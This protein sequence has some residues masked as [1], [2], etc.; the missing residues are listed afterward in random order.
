MVE[1]LE[2]GHEPDEIST[3]LAQGPGGRYLRDWIYGAIDGGVTTFAIVAGVAGAELPN[4]VLLILGCANLL[5]DGFAMAASNYSA[6]KSERDDYNRV[7]DIE[8]RHVRL[9]PEGEREEVRQIFAAKGFAGDDLDRIVDVI[10]GD[11]E[12]WVRTMA[13]EE[14]GHAPTPRSPSRAASS[15]FAAFL[16]CGLVPIVSYLASASLVGCVAATGATFFVVG[17]IKSRWSTAPWW[18]SGL[19]TLGIGMSAAAMAFVVGYGLKNLLPA[20]RS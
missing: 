4:G 20:G 11:A 3:R 12:L 2:H 1:Q 15:T 17:A 14:Y 16:L 18:R 8:R 19:E 13:V 7:L 10:T 6:T 9:A 5:A